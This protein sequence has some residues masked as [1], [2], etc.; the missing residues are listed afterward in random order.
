VQEIEEVV[1]ADAVP[2]SGQRHGRRTPAVGRTG[3]IDWTTLEAYKSKHIQTKESQMKLCRR[4]TTSALVLADLAVLLELAPEPGALARDLRAPHAWLAE[5][6]ADA[7]ASTLA[8]AALWCV[9]G[10][11]A[12]G[13]IA[14]LAIELPGCVGRA[15]NATARILLPGALYRVVAGAVG[16]GIL[17]APVAATADAGVVARTGA[18]PAVASVTPTPPPTPPP[19]LPAPTWPGPPPAPGPALPAP[20]LPDG[21]QPAVRP[22]AS[23]IVRPGDSLWRIAAVHLGERAS[24]ARIAAAWPQ[25][26]AANRTLIGADPDLIAPGQHLQAPASDA[27][28]P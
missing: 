5:V 23:V 7:A 25:W 15:A 8:G 6:G 1:V 13:L 27:A 12:L 18:G 9:A 26:Y 14:A 20:T 24:A 22:A 28:R 21:A 3:G 16:F 11:L 10:W 2:Q 4:L 17:L 19:A